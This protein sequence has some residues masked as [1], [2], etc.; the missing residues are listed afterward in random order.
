MVE[1]DVAAI[2]IN[3]GCPKSFSL[4]GGMGAALLSQPELIQKILTSLKAAIKKPV[5]CKIRVLDDLKA[6]VELAKVIEHTGVDGLAVHGRTKDERPQH[7]NRNDY[8]RAIVKAVDIPVIANGGSSHI[9]C[10]EDIVKFRTAT[11]ASSVM[12][13]RAAEQNCSVFA[14]NGE[15]MDI[16]SLIIEYLKLAIDFDNNA[17]NTK[18]CIQRMLGALQESEKGK[19]ILSKFFCTTT[20]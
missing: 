16:D 18:Y 7:S 3:M 10:F 13:A 8:I 15:R 6:T 11:G 1:E 20:S 12:V 9:Q 5:S 14:K 2:D 17:I 4:K 19:A